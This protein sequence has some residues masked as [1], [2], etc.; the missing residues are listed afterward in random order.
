MIK[1]PL[2]IFSSTSLPAKPMTN[3]PIP[4]IVKKDDTWIPMLD[5][6][7]IKPVTKI[8]AVD[9]LSMTSNRSCLATSLWASS[10]HVCSYTSLFLSCSVMMDRVVMKDIDRIDRIN[11]TKTSLLTR[12]T[13]GTTVS[14]SR[15]TLVMAS[16]ISK[17]K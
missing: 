13:L 14:S 7:N 8:I 9:N 15:A 11:F 5:R 6:F 2:N 10:Y 17:G 12:I 3:D 16:K 4:P 1:K